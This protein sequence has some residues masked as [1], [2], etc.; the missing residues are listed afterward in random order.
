MGI[1]D[2]FYR[3]TL[4]Y[5]SGETT[6][7]I[8]RE[9]LDTG[10]LTINARFVVVRSSEGESGGQ[11]DVLV[12]TLTDISYIKTEKIDSKELR[13]RVAGITS[14]IGGGLDAGPE[15]VSTVEFI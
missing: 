5:T 3:L 8:V 11:T 12:A 14:G 4:R 9:P 10:R 2:N 1:N 6:R 15:A 7:F 13:H